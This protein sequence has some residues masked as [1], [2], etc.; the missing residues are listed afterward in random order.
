MKKIKTVILSGHISF[1]VKTTA[2]L[3]HEKREH[4]HGQ[5]DKASSVEI[6]STCKWVFVFGDGREIAGAGEEKCISLLSPGTDICRQ[7]Q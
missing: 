2:D 1:V 3:V 4:G 7:G 6:E 5:A